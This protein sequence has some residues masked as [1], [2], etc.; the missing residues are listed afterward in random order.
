MPS[1]TGP[2]PR[3]LAL[4]ADSSGAVRITGNNPVKVT[5]TNTHFVNCH[6]LDVANH[7]SCA[8]DL[9]VL[10]TLPKGRAVRSASTAV[11]TR[12]GTARLTIPAIPPRRVT[13]IRIT[14]SS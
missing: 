7:Y 1:T 14:F 2:A 4:K 13:R 12:D 3:V 11:E 5:V 6:G 10:V 9:T 8:R